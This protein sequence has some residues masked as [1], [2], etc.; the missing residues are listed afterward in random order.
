MDIPAGL[1][2]WTADEIA[3]CLPVGDATYRELWR[4]TSE[5]SN[6]KPLGGDGSDGTV[7]WPE[8]TEEYGNQPRAF[9]PNLTPEMQ[10][11]IAQAY[12][13]RNE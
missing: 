12:E 7:E 3:E 2:Y 4:I 8:V 10:A 13:R 5:A 11:D 6:K 1:Q 9:W